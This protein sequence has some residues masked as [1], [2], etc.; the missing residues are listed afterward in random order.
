MKKP[1]QLVG[2]E[3]KL[4]VLFAC[5]SAAVAFVVKSLQERVV[6]KKQYYNKW[7]LK[8]EL[9]NPKVTLF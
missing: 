5:G 4:A 8:C 7:N 9:K 3:T 6:Q 1:T 2:Q